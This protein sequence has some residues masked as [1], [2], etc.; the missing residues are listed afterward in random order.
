LLEAPTEGVEAGE[1]RVVY[2]VASQFQPPGCVALW[3]LA[4]A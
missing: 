4:S 2:F 1:I 3:T